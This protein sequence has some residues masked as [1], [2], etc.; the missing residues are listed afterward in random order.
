M[1]G[2]HNSL[3]DVPSIYFALGCAAWREGKVT[4]GTMA[5]RKLRIWAR[6]VP[7]NHEHRYLLVRAEKERH[8]GR[9]RAALRSYRRSVARAVEREYIHE[10]ALASERA[11]APGVG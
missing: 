6:G 4:D 11:R 10:A 2:A 5:L 9:R 3:S 1:P 7:V 8:F